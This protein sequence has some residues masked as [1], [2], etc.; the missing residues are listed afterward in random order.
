MGCVGSEVC[1]RVS[2]AAVPLPAVFWFCFFFLMIRR[3]PRSTLFPYTTSSDLGVLQ[4]A[5]DRHHH[6]AQEVIAGSHQWL[7]RLLPGREELPELDALGAGRVHRALAVNPHPADQ[8]T[9][10]ERT[11]SLHLQELLDATGSDEIG[12]ASCRERV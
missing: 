2:C 9:R 3:P 8:F 1:A 7:F 6:A 10:G 11:A 5:V 4:G 12:R